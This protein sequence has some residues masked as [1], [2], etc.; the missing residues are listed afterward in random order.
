MFFERLIRELRNEN[1]NLHL[2]AADAIEHLSVVVEE[3]FARPAVQ[4]GRWLPK[5]EWGLHVADE[6]YDKI[7]RCSI[8]GG[9]SLGVSK[10]CPHC[11]KPMDQWI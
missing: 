8:C 1:T 9:E 6:R 11:G 4:P 7:Y 2:D 10:F 5:I 3:L